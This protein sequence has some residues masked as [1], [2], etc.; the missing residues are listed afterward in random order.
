[1]LYKAL[2]QNHGKGVRKATC[3]TS[4]LLHHT[5][6]HYIRQQNNTLTTRCLQIKQLHISEKNGFTT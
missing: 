4:T 2:T 6:F 3:V 1:M 5:V